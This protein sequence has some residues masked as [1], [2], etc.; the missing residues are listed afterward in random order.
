MEYHLQFESDV[1]TLQINYGVRYERAEDSRIEQKDERA[2]AEY[3]GNCQY[4][5]GRFLSFVFCVCVLHF[6]LNSEDQ[7]NETKVMS[8]YYNLSRSRFTLNDSPLIHSEQI[9]I[10][11]SSSSFCSQLVISFACVLFHP[12]VHAYTVPY[13]NAVYESC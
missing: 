3:A 2:T 11:C 13:R 10:K 8:C 12:H 4:F 6:V 7:I 9:D 1:H 5:S